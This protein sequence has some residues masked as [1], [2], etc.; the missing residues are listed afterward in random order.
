MSQQAENKIE[1]IWGSEYIDSGFTPLP[2]IIVRYAPKVLTGREFTLITVIASFKHTKDD[3]YPSQETL[4][5]I[6]G[7]KTRQIRNL[8]DGLY[9]KGLL[10]IY[11]KNNSHGRESCVY[12]F[13]KLLKHCLK[14]HRAE[15]RKK[16]VEEGTKYTRKV[17]PRKKEVVAENIPEPKK[18]VVAENL[19]EPTGIKCATT[20]VQ[21]MPTNRQDLINNN[22]N[23]QSV[24]GN[25]ELDGLII[26]VFGSNLG[27]DKID[28][29][30]NVH[31]FFSEELTPFIYKTVLYKVKKNM[32]KI[33]TS[34]EV[35]LQKAV[36]NEIADKEKTVVSQSNNS[37]SKKKIEVRYGTDLKDLD[38]GKKKSRDPEL[39]WYDF[40]N[41][42][43]IEQKPN[44]AKEYNSEELDNAIEMWKV[45]A[46]KGNVP[47]IRKLNDLGITDFAN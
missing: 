9:D 1:L 47:A 5:E 40:E 19:P 35:Y 3:P 44:S 38:F 24:R 32:S 10:D 20:S 18:E 26:K 11:Y 28:S 16:N 41:C 6:L 33:K 43:V 22:L 4:A 34:F 25:H 37:G 30:Y 27:Q 12:D 8:V 21:N 29:I 45:L 17:K 36:E 15:N 23:K 13:E 14:Q 31:N 2:N 46:T 42:E 39:S 7:I